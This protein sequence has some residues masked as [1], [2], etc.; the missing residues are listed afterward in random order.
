LA[1]IGNLVIILSPAD[2]GP[3]DTA[4][5][6]LEQSQVERARRH[7][8]G[9]GRA[10]LKRHRQV[11]GN[12]RYQFVFLLHELES[13]RFGGRIMT[14]VMPD[15]VENCAVKQVS[16][17]DLAAILSIFDTPFDIGIMSGKPVA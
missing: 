11:H 12:E 8:P 9:A 16:S 15:L 4:L 13:L 6:F 3:Q 5:T 14:A 2:V 7:A 10:F 17:G 1:G